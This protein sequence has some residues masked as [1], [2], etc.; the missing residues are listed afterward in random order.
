MEKEGTRMFSV[1]ISETSYRK[2]KIMSAIK[3]M[4]L[5]DMMSALVEEF[6]VGARDMAQEALDGMTRGEARSLMRNKDLK[7]LLSEEEEK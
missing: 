7:A 3:D 2:L 1:V 5:Q 6:V 4:K